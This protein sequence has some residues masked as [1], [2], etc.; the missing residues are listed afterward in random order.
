MDKQLTKLQMWLILFNV[1]VSIF[2]AT[3][4]G[5]I[6]N[7]ALPIISKELRVT[8]SSIQWVVTSYLLTIS[9]LLLI[10]GKLSDLYGKKKIF[11]FGFIIFTIGSALCGISKNLELLVFSRI[12]QAVGASA[13][14]ALGMGII[15][16]VFP[17]GERG[18]ALGIAGTTV[19]VGSLVGPSLGGILV[20]AY[21]W[22]SIFFINVPIGIL[23]TILTL[24]II[25]EIHDASGV[26]VFDLKGSVLFSASILLLFVGLLFVQ[27]GKLP[28]MLFVLMFLSAVT[29]F[30]IFI[31]LEQ[32][33]DNPLINLSLFKIPEFSLGLSSAFLSFVAIFASL[34][35]MPFYLQYALRLN[36][37]SAGLIIS[38]YPM[39]AAIVAPISGWLSDKITYRPLTVA[40]LGIST[41]VLLKL[42][43]LNTSSSHAEIALLMALLGAGISIFQSPN[44]SSIMGS[45]PKEQLGVAG[46][47]N[48]LFRN[49]GMVSGATLSVLIFSFT[50]KLN[51]NSLTGG[52]S[53]D[54]VL[55]LKG[56]RVVLVFAALSCL[57]A[58][59]I[60]LT[61]AIGVVPT[62]CL[63][64]RPRPD[65]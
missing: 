49:L 19:A 57:V 24:A 8:I 41:L 64:S 27:E 63:E 3:L 43:V 10:W 59:V 4:D 62:G 45:V 53:T 33:A 39:T 26:R 32:R 48:A 17:P 58:V 16:R 60:S 2:M 65:N 12:F 23:G 5:S 51:I 35:F 42:A 15:T 9:V 38:F 20:H 50:T 47:I 21:G 22:Q 6:V 54:A 55:F 61:R 56:Y 11:T 28:P 13:T 46:G 36:T 18:K 14:M 31:R 52:V 1:S 40:G 25:P 7:I 44:N 34:L 30:F 29:A 37:L